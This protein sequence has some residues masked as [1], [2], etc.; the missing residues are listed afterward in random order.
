MKA[1]RAISTALGFTLLSASAVGAAPW[2]VVD[3][4]QTLCYDD[5]GNAITCPG[6]GQPFHGQDAQHAGPAP[7]YRDN[8][9]G[10]VTDQTTGLMW[11]KDPNGHVKATWDDARQGAAGVTTGGY[12]DW[13]LPTIKEL[14]SLIDFNGVTGT[15]AADSTPYLDTDYF[16][17]AY[18][19]TSAGERFIDAQYATDTAY[20][21]TV[22]SGD[23]AVFGVNFADG[24]IKGYGLTNPQGGEFTF[25]VRYVRGGTGYGD[26]DFLDNGDGTITDR[27][28]GLMWTQ[29]DSGVGM[30]WEEALAWTDHRNAETHLGYDD[31]RLPD[32]KE[33]QG[34]LDYGRSPDTTG[35]AAI[36]PAFSVSGIVNEGGQ[37]DF[38]FYWT[39]TTH[40]DGP[41]GIRGSFAGYV[42]F[43]RALGFMEVPPGSG[44]YQLWDVHGAGAQRSDPKQGDPANWPNGNGPQGDVVRI[45]NFVRL[46]RDANVGAGESFLVGPG[47][48]AS[49]PNEVR[50]L[51]AQGSLKQSWLAYGAGS[52]GTNV[53]AAELDGAGPEVVTGPGPGAV[54]GPQVR[55]FGSDGTPVARVNFY[56]Y[57]TLKY[58]VNVGAGSLDADP[59]D[60]LLSGG[61]PG[62]VFGPHVRGFDYDGS[63][64]AL[65]RVNFFAY[66]T[67]RYGVRV[68]GGDVEGDGFAE[69]ISGPGPG[70]I[71][72]AQVRGWNVDGAGVSGLAGINANVFNG[73]THGCQVGLGD[74]DGDGRDEGVF[75]P[76]PGPANPSRVRGF[77][78]D[79]GVTALAGFDSVVFP[80]T[81]YGLT[82]GAGDVDGDGRAEVMAGQGADPA[83][84]STLSALAWSGTALSP[85]PGGTFDAY[86]AVEYGVNATG[87]LY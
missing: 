30:N 45:D 71:F 51:G 29:A 24:R 14:Y 57:G 75:G 76:G 56:A 18:G 42:C 43:G 46:V 84:T 20:V 47:P 3:T 74:V 39:S 19:N 87:I 55:G 17:F 12:T 2:S 44:Q 52:F 15:N 62:A 50:V 22:M 85:L 35:S 31:W 67:L 66:S 7:S 6:L 58:G 77:G 41:V 27:N 59:V 78:L 8:G 25:Y 28:T 1:I 11:Q 79:S 80:A 36:D 5:S 54:Y 40:L 37:A 83:A 48:G 13:R 61:G 65:P 23:P 10:T 21:S 4:A 32:A 34:I 63:L 16:D 9:D 70:A 68:Q 53:A 26:N 38:P 82:A 33:L 69:L 86:P 72:S 64:S 81:A 60:E 73:T 49:N